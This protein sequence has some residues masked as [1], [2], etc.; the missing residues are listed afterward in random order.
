MRNPRRI[1]PIL[2]M[3]EQLWLENPDRRLGRL[4]VD[5]VKPASP[6]PEIFYVEDCKLMALI[7]QRR[8]EWNLHLNGY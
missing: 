4:L 7:Q 1:R 2:H 5:V 6:C 3:I 8:N